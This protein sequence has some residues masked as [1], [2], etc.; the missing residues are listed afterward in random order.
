MKQRIEA[1]IEELLGKDAPEFEPRDP[2][3]AKEIFRVADG[4]LEAFP[5]GEVAPGS[6]GTR[7]ASAYH[8][9]RGSRRR[10]RE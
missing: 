3:Q 6:D 10:P 8:P 9:A 1:T 5:H 2:S 7:D 4:L